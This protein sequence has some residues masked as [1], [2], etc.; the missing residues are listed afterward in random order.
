MADDFQQK[1]MNMSDTDLDFLATQG[2]MQP[3]QINEI[4]A[5]KYSQGVNAP[6]AEADDAA[7]RAAIQTPQGQLDA[8]QQADTVVNQAM[9]GTQVAPTF[10]SVQTP[11]TPM[12]APNPVQHLPSTLLAPI[13]Q[14]QVDAEVMAKA[15]T[16]AAHSGAQQ[17]VANFKQQQMER[18]VAAAEAKDKE[19]E[20]KVQ[21]DMDAEGSWGSR[22][23]QAIA[24][25]MGSASQGLTGAKENPAVQA[26]E[27]EIK[28]QSERMQY[29]K[30][31]EDKMREYGLKLANLEMERKKH[32]LDTQAKRSNMEKDQA[33]IQ[34]IQAELEMQKAN[35]AIASKREFTPE[36]V[37]SIPMDKD[38]LN[39]RNLMVRLP[40]G[41]FAMATRESG[42]Q[43]LAEMEAETTG[44]LQS[45]NALL[46]KIDYFGNNPGKKIL[47]RVE[48]AETNAIAQGLVGAMRLPYLGPGT[49]TDT[50]RAILNSVV[51]DPSKLLTLSSANK[52]SVKA[53]V[54]KIKHFRN[55]SYR[56]NGVDL[57]PTQNDMILK[58]AKQK[59]PTATDAQLIEAL[60]RQGKW[61]PNEL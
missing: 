10:A 3:A 53:V 47:D 5:M 38:G 6:Q 33:E 59:Y 32:E 18:D 14:E 41:N 39:M 24:I 60:V 22:I 19:V 31:Q 26:I 49:V 25:M 1:L 46:A 48:V 34:K 21:A 13:P 45:A 30:E 20:E 51:R 44:A 36:E 61:N 54:A 16:D 50:E 27:K 37:T 11:S 57:P 12:Q 28:R 7:N 2:Y 23:G 52:A 40:N 17:G 43:K 35:K 56:A 42:A 58:Q 8:Q 9:Q 4:K 55:A 29:T 15:Q